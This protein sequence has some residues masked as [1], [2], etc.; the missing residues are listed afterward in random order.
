MADLSVEAKNKMVA[1]SGRQAPPIARPMDYTN[2]AYVEARVN[3]NTF[4]AV[5]LHYLNDDHHRWLAEYATGRATLPFNIEDQWFWECPITLTPRRIVIGKFLDEDR[6]TLLKDRASVI[7]AAE[8]PFRLSG[9]PVFIHNIKAIFRAVN[10]IASPLK[11]DIKRYLP[12]AEYAG[13]IPGGFGARSDGLFASTGEGQAKW[14]VHAFFH[15]MGHNTPGHL[16]HGPAEEVR[17]DEYADRACALLG[18]D[19]ARTRYGDSVEAW[20]DRGLTV[21]ALAQANGGQRARY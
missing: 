4:V 13:N 17:A 16:G 3:I 18:L 9:P 19:Y 7:D 14:F 15:E 5:R 8:V 21:L 10:L 12:K 6:R 20:L 1:A 11:E 2:R